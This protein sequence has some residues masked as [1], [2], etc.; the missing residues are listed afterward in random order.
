MAVE[1]GELVIRKPLEDL[2]TAEAD[3]LALYSWVSI[4][5]GSKEFIPIGKTIVLYAKGNTV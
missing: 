4:V 5:A 3:I 1:E 2:A